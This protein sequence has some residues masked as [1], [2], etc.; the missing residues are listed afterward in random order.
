MQNDETILREHETIA[1]IILKT[2]CAFEWVQVLAQFVRV[3]N[4]HE[5]EPEASALSV[6]M[7]VVAVRLPSSQVMSSKISFV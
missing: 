2:F 3:Y 1:I 5:T 4:L 7:A 6:S